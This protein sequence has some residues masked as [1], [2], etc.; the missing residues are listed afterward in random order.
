M[1]YL[2]KQGLQWSDFAFNKVKNLKMLIIIT[3][4]FLGQ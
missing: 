2:P 1:L 4:F 3:F